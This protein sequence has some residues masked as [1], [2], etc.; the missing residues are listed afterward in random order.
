MT[1]QPDWQRSRL[2]DRLEAIRARSAKSTSWRGTTS[3]LLKLVNHEG[4]V[5]VKTRLSREDLL[6]LTSAR[7]ELTGFAELGL[8]I[9][10][11]H[12]P[13]DGGGVSSDPS[14]PLRRCRSCMGRWPCPTYRALTD[15]LDL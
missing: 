6:F 7:D 8:R 5:P 14:T 11:L 10:E 3:Y 12:Q 1:N 9:L 2:R 15:T 13:R 4:Q